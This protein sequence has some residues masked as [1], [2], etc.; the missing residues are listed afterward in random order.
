MLAGQEEP[1]GRDACV[2]FQEVALCCSQAKASR[3]SVSRRLGNRARGCGPQRALAVFERPS[4]KRLSERISQGGLTTRRRR[5]GVCRLPQPG[6]P[7]AAD[8][9]HGSQRAS[10]CREHA[11]TTHAQTTMQTIRD[12]GKNKIFHTN[13]T[14][15]R[16]VCQAARQSSTGTQESAWHRDRS[17][18]SNPNKEGTMPVS[19]KKKHITPAPDASILEPS[20]PQL[21]GQQEFLQYLRTLARECRSDGDRSRHARRVRCLPWNRL[22]MEEL[23]KMNT[24]GQTTTKPHQ[25]KGVGPGRMQKQVPWCSDQRSRE[26]W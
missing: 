18:D 12:E 26:W 23:G 22:G 3:A 1:A 4:C 15:Y 24:Q 16:C 20:P 21:P 17:I 5:V 8:S 25:R 13:Y 11:R 7:M 14:C 10:G 19:R 9:G 6:S 2:A